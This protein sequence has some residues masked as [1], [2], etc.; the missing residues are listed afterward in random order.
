MFPANTIL[1]SLAELGIIS[2]VLLFAL[3]ASVALYN[4]EG[5]VQAGA[6]EKELQGH[7]MQNGRTS[8]Y[9]YYNKGL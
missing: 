7:R 5:K 9:F 6:V 8:N 4:R 1:R 2:G 3:P